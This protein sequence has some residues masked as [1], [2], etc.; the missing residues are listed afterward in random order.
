MQVQIHHVN[1]IVAMEKKV[2]LTEDQIGKKLTR[3]A[4]QIWESH[5]DATVIELVGITGGGMVIA[6]ALA[7]ILNKISPLVCNIS[8]LHLNKRNPL[9]DPITLDAALDGKNVVLVDDVA[10]SGKTL[11]FSL[12]P[13]L[14]VMPKKLTI[15]VL[16]DREHKNF[17]IVPN[18]IGY[19]IATT[20][21]DMI[22][23]NYDGDRLTSAHLE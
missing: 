21:Q 19:A 13:I 7:T 17:P 2:I 6:K 8:E 5:S 14:E 18:I 23:V 15:A 3:M 1:F 4:Y 9:A 16:I 12:K 20:I 10:N 22:L 11:M